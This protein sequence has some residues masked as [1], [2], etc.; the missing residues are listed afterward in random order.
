MRDVP[1]SVNTP[2][3]ATISIRL[4]PIFVHE[5]HDGVLIEGQDGTGCTSNPPG[6]AGPWEDT[7][8]GEFW[9][10]NT[11]VFN[12]KCPV[13]F[14]VLLVVGAQGIGYGQLPQL[15]ASTG[16]PM[17]EETLDGGKLALPSSD[18]AYSRYTSGIGDTVILTEYAAGIIVRNSKD[19][20][21]DTV[22]TAELH[23]NSQLD[24]NA[25]PAFSAGTDAVANDRGTALPAEMPVTAGLGPYA[26]DPAKDINTLDTAGND[27]PVGIWS[28]GITMWV[29]D[30]DDHKLYAYNLST[31]VRDP[32]RDFNT[33]NGVGNDK[34]TA[35]WSDGITMWVADNSDDKLYAYNL[36]TRARD[37][38][39]DFNTLDAAGN[40]TPVGIWSDGV[41]MWMADFVDVKLYAYNLS[42]RARDPAR[43]FN[44]LDAAGNETPVGI[45]SNG[46]TMW[47]ADGIDDKLYAYNLSTSVRGPARD[48][49]TLD[50]AGNN[51][52]TDI[53]SDGATMWVADA[54]DE[55]LYAY[56][57]AV[58]VPVTPEQAASDF[59]GDGIVNF[60]DFFE[61]VDAFGS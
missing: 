16:S 17:K 35:I 53:W 9:Y 44:T 41:T 2:A 1:S 46:I 40:E 20:A 26:R 48:F 15:V 28:D 34:P 3:C 31:S 14:S 33:L 58:T 24:N 5:A 32:A 49:N 18:G 50:A 6:N 23:F 22:V 7:F 39:K 29:A 54:D 60:A 19:W 43:D 37:P 27:T 42:T 8:P 52:P 21:V 30:Y 25:V 36:S 38:A 13:L 47:V 61:F 11:R 4:D 55:R 57:M 59:N 10:M 51:K 56:D 45:W 12:R